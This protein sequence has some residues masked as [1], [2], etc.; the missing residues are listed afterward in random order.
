MVKSALN[1]GAAHRRSL[2]QRPLDRGVERAQA[3]GHVGP[4]M[5]S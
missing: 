2:R 1:L 5:H 3:G 4:D